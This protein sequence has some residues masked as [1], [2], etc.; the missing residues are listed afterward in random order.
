MT[1]TTDNGTA[2]TKVFWDEPSASDY[3]G[4]HDTLFSLTSNHKP[5]EV[6]SVGDTVVTY[7]AIDLAG[8]RLTKSFVVSIKGE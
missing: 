4:A 1:L 7:T 5:G 3:Y 8:N 6:F 2:S